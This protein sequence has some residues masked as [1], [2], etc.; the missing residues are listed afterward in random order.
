[1]P[2]DVLENARLG[3]VSTNVAGILDPVEQLFDQGVLVD[4]DDEIAFS[5]QLYMEFLIEQGI[6][7]QGVSF[8][9]LIERML[10]IVSESTHFIE[11]ELNALGNIL[12]DQYSGDSEENEVI[13]RCLEVRG[14]ATAIVPF[15]TLLKTDRP[16][17]YDD[18][19]EQLL[20]SADGEALAGL[21]SLARTLGDQE[22]ML[23]TLHK[24]RERCT[25]TA[26]ALPLLLRISRVELRIGRLAESAQ[27]L[28]EAWFKIRTGNDRDMLLYL[29][30][31]GYHTVFTGGSD[32][33]AIYD[34]A[35]SVLDAAFDEGSEGHRN[36]L[37]AILHGRGCAAHNLDLTE[38]CLASH[39]R[40]LELSRSI[41]DVE[42]E[43]I[44]LVNL[45]DAFWA[46]GRPT[47]ALELYDDAIDVAARAWF[48]NARDVA[49]IGKATVL[50]SLGDIEGAASAVDEGIAL[51]RLLEQPW[52][53]AWGLTYR[54]GILATSDQPEQ[55]AQAI[56]R[57]EN[58]AL[59]IDAKY[60]QRLAHAY[61][62]W[63]GLLNTPGTAKDLAASADFI[64][65]CEDGGYRGP[66]MIA[67]CAFI[68][69]AALSGSSDESIEAA[70]NRHA[71]RILETGPFKGP[72][73][74]IA[75]SVLQRVR[76]V[77]PA[78]DMFELEHAL[79]NVVMSKQAQMPD[80]Y[81]SS[82]NLTLERLNA[83]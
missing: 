73:E 80:A 39:R 29:C 46:S 9:S 37:H 58:I 59:S 34:R 5:H 50:W 70:A 26:E 60:L 53:E 52:D 74:F 44:D 38:E 36:N 28:D 18:V 43:A 51:A 55:A 41:G 33:I 1:M 49:L 61:G 30:E 35:L 6:R 27:H 56:E 24:M 72:W 13:L 40:A 67:E 63:I 23:A 62:I 16:V 10:D 65:L 45:A 11:E 21:L 2:Q 82:H 19:V 57:A 25:D 78:C 54:A 20:V 66:A 12:I 22:T 31:Q 4:A 64:R 69:A 83:L 76:R 42:A 47:E 68:L 79:M 3:R 77:R 71:Q 81:R 8:I 17:F 7:K 15:L 32:V 48:D 14:F 75:T